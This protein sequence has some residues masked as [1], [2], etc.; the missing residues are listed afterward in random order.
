MIFMI[1]KFK[2]PTIF[3][4]CDMLKT[5]QILTFTFLTIIFISQT[6]IG[7]NC[8]VERWSVKTLSDND[9]LKIDFKKLIKST[10]HEQVLMAPPIKKRERLDSETKVYSI[11]CFI[12][13]YKKEGNDKDIHIIIEDI[14]TDETMVI[15]IPSYECFDIQ[16]TSRY[17]LFKE[18]QEW[19]SKNIGHPTSKFVY[20]EKHIPV[21]ITGVGYFDFVHGQKGMAENGREIHPVL[22]IQLK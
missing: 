21:T 7:Q 22:S 13:G 15:E 12:I 3:K 18:L 5:L 17:E 8:G 6:S 19:F 1:C 16:K 11:D 9:T 10:V 2:T 20:L 14:N 4:L